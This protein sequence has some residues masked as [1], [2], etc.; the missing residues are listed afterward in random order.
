M[1]KG[2]SLWLAGVAVVVLALSSC[3]AQVAPEGWL[4]LGKRNVNFRNDRDTIIVSGN[5]RPLSQLMVLARNYPVTIY[6]VR[7]FFANGTSFDAVNRQNL[8]PGGD[9]LYIDLPGGQRTVRE[10]MFRYSRLPGKHKTAI[11]EL[12]GR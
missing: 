9:R 2:K 3:V 12:Y 7:V 10:V 6:D 11:V 5:V 4:Y 1:T 8:Y